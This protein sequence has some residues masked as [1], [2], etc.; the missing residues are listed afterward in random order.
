MLIYVI[1]NDMLYGIDPSVGALK[2]YLTAVK[3]GKTIGRTT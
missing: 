1:L 2:N 3:T